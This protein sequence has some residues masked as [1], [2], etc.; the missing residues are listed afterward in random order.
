MG[1]ITT[2]I[3]NNP[4]VSDSTDEL[5]EVHQDGSSVFEFSCVLFEVEVKL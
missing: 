2:L 1:P 5:R 4:V 3:I